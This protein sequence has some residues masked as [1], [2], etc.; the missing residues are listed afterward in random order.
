MNY[1]LVLTMLAVPVLLNA[2]SPKMLASTIELRQ[3]DTL[4]IQNFDEKGRSVFEKTFPQYGISMVR[5]YT[6]AG[7]RLD[8]EIWWHSNVGMVV[9]EYTY[10]TLRH[11]RTTWS[12][13]N[14]KIAQP[15]P[16]AELMAFNTFAQLHTSEPYKQLSAKG[17]K[18]CRQIWYYFD[19]LLTREVEMD[20][21]GD[22]SN[23]TTYTY[24][25]GN[26]INTKQ[27]YGHNH[28][29]NE[30]TYNYDSAGRE[31]QWI[32]TF[33]VT[34]TAAVLQKT[35]DGRLITTQ[36]LLEDGSLNSYTTYEYKGEQLQT[37]K[38]FDG[39][40]RLRNVRKYKYYPDKSLYKVITRDKT[41]IHLY[42]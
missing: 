38:E 23:I 19:T 25:N 13:S 35:Y 27:V 34:D 15:S 29:Y 16:V 18:Y 12:L 24:R 30:L 21:N 14:D 17:E 9:S 22:T 11:T 20:S 8:S 4:M 2:Q 6:Y 26:V 28:A 40:H 7:D 3:S 31:I 36:T 10:D 42:R 1:A 5:A 39:Q 32:K 33:N 41:I 37:E